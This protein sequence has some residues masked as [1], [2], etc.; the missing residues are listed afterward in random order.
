MSHLPRV[1]FSS[2]LV[3]V[4]SCGSSQHG[5][6]N[7]GV[8]I[9]V[10]TDNATVWRHVEDTASKADI[11][12]VANISNGPGESIDN[13]YVQFIQDVVKNGGKVLGYVATDYGSRNIK[14]VLSDID[15][16][17]AFYG[18]FISG[19]FLD[20][21]KTGLYDY[22]EPISSH[23]HSL[24]GLVFMNG[25]SSDKGYQKL[26]DIIVVFESNYTAFRSFDVSNYKFPESA[27]IVY[28]VSPD[29]LDDVIKNVNGYRYIFITDLGRPNPYR[30]IPSYYDKL[31]D[32]VGGKGED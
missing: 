21:V 6:V 16:W 29:D 23:I 31:L 22:Y 12:A 28:G 14:D 2:F 5:T 8:L 27:I 13:N 15:K 25:G 18:R 30:N 11:V 20:E 10:Y 4:F 19:I 7:M 3:L 17:Y 1:L 32:Y 26:A 9:P 24:G